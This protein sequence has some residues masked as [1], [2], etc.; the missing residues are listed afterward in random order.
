MPA[1]CIAEKLL[2][3]GHQILLLTDKRG[4][5][6]I[7]NHLSYKVVRSASPFAGSAIRRVAALFQLG[8]GLVYCLFK[9]TVKRPAVMVG[10]GGYPAA[11]PVFAA[12]CLGIPEYL[13]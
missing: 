5:Q 9:L 11:A 1:I 13:A 10:F 7:P 12:S 3:D 6:L 4:A 8:A 2:A